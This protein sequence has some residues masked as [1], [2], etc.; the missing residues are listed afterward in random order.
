MKSLSDPRASRSHRALLDA[1]IEVLLVNPDASLSDIARQAGVGR[2]TLYRHFESREALVL[3]L[4]QE[5]LQVT[6]EILAPI[7]EQGLGARETIA[8][9]LEA[10]MQVADRFH[11]LL[12]LWHVSAADA[13]VEAIYRR[14]LDDLYQLIERGKQEGAIAP[15]LSTPWI[16]NLIDSLVYAGWWSIRS[17]EMTAAQAGSHAVRVLFY[18]ISTKNSPA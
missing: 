10:I 18:G 15:G 9:G 8:K 1:A 11:F 17:Q 2:A 12:L 7:T 16:V 5:S 14:Q 6:D 3:Q 13:R 4:A